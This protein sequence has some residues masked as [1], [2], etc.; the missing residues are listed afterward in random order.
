MSHRGSS[1]FVYRGLAAL[2]VAVVGVSGLAAC[3]SSS[4][5]SGG[6]GSTTSSSGGGATGT[7]KVAILD[8]QTGTLASYG[9]ETARGSQMALDKINDAGGIKVGNTTYKFSYTITDLQ[10]DAT[11]AASAAQTAIQNGAQV[12]LGPGVSAMAQP[13]AQAVQRAIFL[14]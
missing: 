6:G 10:S 13:V 4:K 14:R 11:I 5:S 7:I 2:S 1:R 3:S 12:I 9:R 8:A